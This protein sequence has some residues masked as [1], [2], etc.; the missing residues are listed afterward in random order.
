MN[1]FLLLNVGYAFVFV[2]LAVNREIDGCFVELVAEVVAG[3]VL[4]G[5]AEVLHN[6]LGEGLVRGPVAGDCRQDF[7]GIKPRKYIF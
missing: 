1:R 7:R 3:H 5:E 4:A 2:L 6:L